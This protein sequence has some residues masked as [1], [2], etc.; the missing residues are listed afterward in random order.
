MNESVDSDAFVM[1]SSSG[2]PSAGSPPRPT[3]IPSGARNQR[4]HSY[5]FD[6]FMSEARRALTLV[7]FARAAASAIVRSAA[8]TD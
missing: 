7:R 3:S 4:S 1:P 5:A 2:V 6:F 8:F